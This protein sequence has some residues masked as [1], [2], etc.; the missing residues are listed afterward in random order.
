MNGRILR[1]D[2]DAE[3]RAS[4]P[5][6]RELRPN[7]GDAET[8]LA[9]VRR[10]MADGYRL[11]LRAIDGAEGMEI[12]AGAGWRLTEMLAFGKFLYVDD[13]VTAARHRGKGHGAA[14]MQW[15]EAEARAAGCA[16]LA[17]DSGTH[18]TGAH[19]FY[20]REGLA[21]TSFHFVKTLAQRDM[22]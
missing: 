11:T 5:V 22:R 3:I 2:S 12:V 18:R 10:Q 9:A 16:R 6:L 20:F 4:F 13:L 14:L 7:F 8:Y 17:L 19:R 1:A 15:L 21:I